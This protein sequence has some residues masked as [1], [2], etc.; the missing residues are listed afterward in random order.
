MIFF[1]QEKHHSNST[2]RKV[3]TSVVTL[4][5]DKVRESASPAARDRE[6]LVREEGVA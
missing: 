6:Q 3:A 1:V 5:V 2:Y 4:V